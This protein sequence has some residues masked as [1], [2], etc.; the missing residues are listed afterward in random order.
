ASRV[1]TLKVLLRNAGPMEQMTDRSSRELWR[2]IRDCVPFADGTARPVWRVSMAPSEAHKMVLALRMETG[3][4]AFYDWQ[5]GLIWL[6]M[7]AE[8][9][10]EAL[11][12]RVRQFGGGHA[13]LMR[14]SPAWR[15]AVP[16]FEPQAPAL[17]ALSARLKA[18][19]DPK[20]ILN[21]G[22]M[23]AAAN[24]ATLVQATEEN[25]S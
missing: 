14:A 18:E 6:R 21:P 5:G 16:V 23:A 3:A 13:T 24:S 15:T 7:E 19:F 20:N 25:A 12:R 22:R 8:P 4:D 9:E 10:S 1:E 11:R 17:A 2:D